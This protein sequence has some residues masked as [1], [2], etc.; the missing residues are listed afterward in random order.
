[1]KGKTGEEAAPASGMPDKLTFSFFLPHATIGKGKKVLYDQISDQKSSA[2]C[3]QCKFR[4]VLSLPLRCK[5]H[6]G[7]SRI[8]QVFSA[9]S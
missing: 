5:E 8:A 4:A 3:V 7:L 6:V 9:A 1:M 2:V